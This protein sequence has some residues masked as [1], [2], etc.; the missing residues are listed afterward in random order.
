MRW[1][2]YAILAVL[3]VILIV[4][5]FKIQ[6]V[7][8]K[9]EHPNVMVCNGIV[10]DEKM[11]EKIVSFSN[12]YIKQMVGENYFREHLF[13]QNYYIGKDCTFQVRYLYIVKSYKSEV[14]V[15]VIPGFIL[16]IKGS[17]APKYPF[18]IKYNPDQ[19]NITYDNYDLKY[20]PND[21]FY[22]IFYKNGLEVGIG[23]AMSGKLIK[24]EVVV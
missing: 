15:D 10:I 18:E 20:D 21:G 1:L 9:I 19:F 16:S 4:A 14:Y 5:F 22:Y 13:Y 23:N 6:K 8:Y 2:S 11:K 24:E 12:D 7:Q 17:N 3:L